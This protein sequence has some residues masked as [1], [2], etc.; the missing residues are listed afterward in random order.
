LH[1]FDD[2]I[3][4]L[5]LQISLVQK[6]KHLIKV[7]LVVKNVLKEPIHLV[8]VINIHLMIQ[9][10]LYQHQNSHLKLRHYIVLLIVNV[11]NRSKSLKIQYLNVIKE[12]MFFRVWHVKGNALQG[13]VYPNCGIELTFRFKLEQPGSIT[14]TYNLA[15]SYI[16]GT[17][18]KRKYN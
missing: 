1:I 15:T 5:I 8:E 3:L 4:F 17:V 12:K 6:D 10:N 14:L 13:E 11:T 16:F 7:H 9:K 18:N 2:V